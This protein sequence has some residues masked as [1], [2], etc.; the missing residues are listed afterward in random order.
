MK[1]FCILLALTVS[2]ASLSGC[3]ELAG[4]IDTGAILEQVETIAQQI[5]VEALV[6]RAIES[7][8]WEELKVSAEKGYD[9]LTEKHPALKGENIKAYLKEN[10]LA[11]LNRY[12]SGSDE[13]MQEN[14]RKLGEILKI[15]TPELADEVD[16]ILG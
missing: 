11:L 9:A 15:L 14:A 3:A 12:V 7:I 16:T 13:S 4:T 6:T 10:G 2:L 8:D 1:K 5:D